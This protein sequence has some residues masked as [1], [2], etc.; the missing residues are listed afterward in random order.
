MRFIRGTARFM[1]VAALLAPLLRG[2]CEQACRKAAIMVVLCVPSPMPLPP[3]APKPAPADLK[4]CEDCIQAN[5]GPDVSAETEPEAATL[6]SPAVGAELDATATFRWTKGVRIKRYQI[7]I[8]LTRGGAD[9]DITGWLTDQHYTTTKIPPKKDG[10]VFVTLRSN[11]DDGRDLLD[12]RHY[13]TLEGATA[14]RQPQTPQPPPPRQPLLQQPPPPQQPPPSAQQSLEELLFG[15]R[16]AKPV[17][18]ANLSGAWIAADG[19]PVFL[20]QDGAVVI[21]SF[22]GVEARAAAVGT[23][24]ATFDGTALNGAYQ[25]LE[26]GRVTSGQAWFRVVPG[27]ELNGGWITPDGARGLWVLK[28]APTTGPQGPNL[29]GRWVSPDG[30]VFQIIHQGSRVTATYRASAARPNLT[31]QILAVFD[32]STVIGSFESAEGGVPTSGLVRLTVS[33]DGRRL[34]GVW[35]DSRGYRGSWTLTR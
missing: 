21:G 22:R 11:T 5:C 19:A 18:A 33:T 14:Y 24:R 34:D 1:V 20:S 25:I 12:S 2:Q 7:L 28:R 26:G 9:V 35:T 16:S 17:P 13:R 30:A 31:R 8:G 4:A 32:G 15:T 3:G 10:M 23:I 27:G 6:T 29:S